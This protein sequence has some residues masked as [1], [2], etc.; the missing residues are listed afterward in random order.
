MGSKDGPIP[1]LRDFIAVSALSMLSNPYYDEAPN[2][3]IAK[4]CY[5]IADAM[6]IEREKIN[7]TTK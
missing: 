6:L 7:A 4:F 3:E 5:G 1:G 2:W